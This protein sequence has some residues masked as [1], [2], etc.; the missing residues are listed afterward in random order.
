PR[1][2]SRPAADR[3]DD[4]WLRGPRGGDGRHRGPDALRAVATRERSSRKVSTA[5]G[6]RNPL[7]KDLRVAVARA[8]LDD[9][10]PPASGEREARGHGE[11]PEQVVEGPFAER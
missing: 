2:G 11:R 10:A 5:E 1:P 4:R 3:P 9:D 8:H 6:G 7:S